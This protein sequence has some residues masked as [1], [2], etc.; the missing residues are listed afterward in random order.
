MSARYSSL[1]K[2]EWPW[3]WLICAFL[4][5]AAFFLRL[6]YF[7]VSRG[8][9]EVQ[10]RSA[11]IARSFYFER[12]PEIPEWRKE[13]NRQTV[14][15]L[16]VK[17]PSITEYLATWLYR[18]F[19]GENLRLARL[20]TTSFWLVGGVLL[21]QI[22]NRVVSP[23]AAVLGLV[24]YL[25]VP[26]GVFLSTSF[27]PD[28]LMIML[29]IA[30]LS[31]IL[32]YGLRPSFTRLAIAAVLSGLAILAKP[33][34]LFATGMAFLCVAWHHRYTLGKRFYVHV[35]FFSA[36]FLLIGSSYY[37]YG[38]L[39]GNTLQTQAVSS[40]MP[41][42]LLR[43]D[44]WRDWLLTA[45]STVG[46][47]PLF[48]ALV[49]LPL[50]RDGVVRMLVAGLWL[51]YLLFC[52][53]FT[54]HIRFNS[55]Y[56]AQLIVIVALSAG[57]IIVV[58]FARLQERIHQWR[59][60]LPVLAALLLWITLMVRDTHLLFR[61]QAPVED[62]P[63]AA[64][65]GKLV[66]HSSETVSVAYYYGRPLMYLGELSGTHWPR[67]ITEDRTLLEGE[68]RYLTVQERLDALSFSPAYFIITNFAEFTSHHEDLRDY[69]RENCSLK[70]GSNQYQIYHAC[71]R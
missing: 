39:I 28:S 37:F 36:V 47:M 58:T 71:Q 70:A 60:W 24:Y 57:P 35:A 51:G 22:I 68:A 14:E 11:L 29:F 65:I 69:L 6:H 3:P 20:L 41:A 26:T 17:E 1:S 67:A 12:T 19:G 48:L 23:A 4:L 66:G 56:H 18:L 44:Y 13:I 55:Y 25:L 33:L 21:F 62:V 32:S 27:Q 5:L 7:D 42:L 30:A 2:L 54:Y 63:V 46:I 61:Y 8:V 59:W 10:Y 40:F 49:G 31:S 38:F 34:I 15:I 50:L 9:G 45:S 16:P 52:L 64:E 43:P 53:I